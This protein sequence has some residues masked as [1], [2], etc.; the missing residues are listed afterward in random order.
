MRGILK[1]TIL[2]G[3]NTNSHEVTAAYVLRF[4]QRWWSPFVLA[5]AG[6]LIFDPRAFSGASTQARAAFV[7]GAGADVNLS[8]YLF[9]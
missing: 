2:F 7:Y 5:G 6:G 4:F 3:V 9:L 1:T 8:E